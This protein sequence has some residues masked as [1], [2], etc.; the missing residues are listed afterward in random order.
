MGTQS[1]LQNQQTIPHESTS[2]QHSFTHSKHTYFI[3]HTLLTKAV[4]PRGTVSAGS[5]TRSRSGL[6]LG[7]HPL[8]RAVQTDRL[9]AHRAAEPL[10]AMWEPIPQHRS[11][12]LGTQESQTGVLALL[13]WQHFI[14]VHMA[15]H[16][17]VLRNPCPAK[18]HCTG[19]SHPLSL[20]TLQA[21]KG[22]AAK[23]ES[24][25]PCPGNCSHKS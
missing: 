13:G 2:Q 17:K 21:A 15:V 3:T 16:H 1:T 18:H 12:R 7:L 23:L 11:P 9:S 22:T 6:E 20:R 14:S 10:A 24:P 4:Q 19:A 25:P 8:Q 5:S